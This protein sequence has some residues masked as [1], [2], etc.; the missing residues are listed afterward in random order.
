MKKGE[1]FYLLFVRKKKDSNNIIELT[2]LNSSGSVS[3]DL[4]EQSTS[5]ILH[6]Y[7][8]VFPDDLPK[9]LPPK[10]FI[11]HKIKLEPGSTPT[12]KHHHRLSPQDLDEL[13]VHLK[14]LLDHGFIRESHSPYGAPILC[15]KKAG[16][17]KRRLCIDY[18]DLNRITIKDRYPLPRV[19]ELMDRLFGA[20]Y[21]TKL[22]LRSGYHQVRVAAEDIQKTAFNTRYG[23]YEYLVVPF[24]LTSAPSTFM[25]LMNHILNPYLDKFAIAYLDDVLIYSKTFEDHELHVRTI[26]NEFR[27]H[28][29]YAK[30][31]KCEFFKSEV[32][33]LGFIVGADGVKV[34]PAKVEA[35]KF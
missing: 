23:Q 27:K 25:A 28:K 34:D 15:A 4:M 14:D 3:P 16:D 24:G 20:K 12:F 6:E 33:F 32:K 19:D 17:T 29:L 2:N 1:Q 10:R 31:S 21:F 18:R 8:D 7:P 22:D 35:V 13:K 30:E 5:Q 9:G 26:L 11:E